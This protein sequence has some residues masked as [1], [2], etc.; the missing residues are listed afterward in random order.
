MRSA[1]ASA[2]CDA[3]KK[4]KDII[5]IT[6]DLGFAVWDNFQKE[7]PQQ[8]LNC[9]VAE[10]NMVGIA[11]GLALSGKIVFVYSIIP[12]AT[13]RCLEQIR[14]DICY[15]NVAVCVVGVGSGYSYGYMG[16]THHALEDVAVM[17]SLANMTVVVPGDPAEAQA[18]VSCIVRRARP[19]YLRLGKDNEKVIHVHP[20][21]VGETFSLGKAIQVQTPSGGD[22]NE[23]SASPSVVAI[24]SCGTMLETAV[25][26]AKLLRSQKV[27]CTVWSFHTLK[28]LDRAAILQAAS[29]VKLLVTIE[30]H[31]SIGGLGSAVAEV[32]TSLRLTT[33]LLVCAAPDEFSDQVG[34]QA[35]LRNH[36]GLTPEKIVEKINLERLL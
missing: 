32:V 29:S 7:C 26:V 24:L 20:L 16:S 36:V 12:F 5:L 28:P 6:G 18:A 35:F 23:D 1:F 9:G 21:V 30:E 34:S 15:H 4:N 31:S 25:Q 2:F 27:P 11:A 17:R 3:A 10:Q 14:N 13:F 33:P 22:C 19:C 8:Y